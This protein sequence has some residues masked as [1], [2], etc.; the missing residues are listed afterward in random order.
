M[1]Y[2]YTQVQ[3]YWHLQYLNLIPFIAVSSILKLKIIWENIQKILIIKHHYLA[4]SP[5]I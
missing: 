5:Q 2:I 3:T 1:Q 4:N